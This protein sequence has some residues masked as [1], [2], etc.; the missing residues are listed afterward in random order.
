MRDN[1]KA[2][3]QQWTSHTGLEGWGG[4][5]EDRMGFG[6]AVAALRGRPSPLQ[7]TIHES[8]GRPEEQVLI[9]RQEITNKADAW[10]MQEFITHMYIKQ[11]LRHPAF[12]LLLALL[13]VINA[14]TIAL[15][16][17]SYLDQKHYELFSTIDDIV[18]TILLCEVLLGWLNGF[19]IFWKDGWNILNFIIVF[20]LLLRFF[21]NEINIPSINYTLR[22][23]RLVHVCM[24]VE[25]LARIIRVILQSVPD[26]AN[27]MVLILFFMLVFSVFGVTL[28]GA[29]VPKH[30]QNIQV[31]LYTLFICITQDGWVD[32]YSDFQV[33]F[34]PCNGDLSHHANQLGSWPWIR[35]QVCS[36]AS[37]YRATSQP[38]LEPTKLPELLGTSGLISFILKPTA[39]IHFCVLFFTSFLLSLSPI[40]FQFIPESGTP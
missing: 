26:M 29:F 40:S 3:W 9:N 21:I 25:P 22:A 2:W 27:I 4:T 15:R 19:W 17:N 7:S 38:T 14:I 8:Y 18:L 35:Q 32:I 33:P 34:P 5:Q 12:Q 11:L 37:G 16:T 39:H 6:G 30:F 28:F 24:A 23:L 10:D 31:A 1:E 36:Y 13:L 20:I